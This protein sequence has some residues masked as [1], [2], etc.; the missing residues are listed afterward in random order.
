MIKS[1]GRPPVITISTMD[2][3]A[4]AIQNN[5]S[6][7]DACAYG[8]ISRDSFYR[9]LKTEPLFTEKIKAAYKNQSTFVLCHL[10]SGTYRTI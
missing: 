8:K 2:K 4:E 6:V 1:K 5:Y 3:V 10:C 9:Y 7:T